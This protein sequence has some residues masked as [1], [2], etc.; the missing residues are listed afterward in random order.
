MLGLPND[1]SLNVIKDIIAAERNLRRAQEKAMKF[2][3][4]HDLAENETQ[5]KVMINYQ[6]NKERE[7]N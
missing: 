3:I 1:D 2:Y 5:A 7:K 4:T 6:Q